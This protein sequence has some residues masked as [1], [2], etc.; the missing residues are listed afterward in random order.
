MNIERRK[1]WSVTYT[2]LLRDPKGML[3]YV[4]RFELLRAIWTRYLAPI[5]QFFLD[6]RTESKT[7]TV[8]NHH[9]NGNSEHV[10]LR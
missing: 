8:P 9:R 10:P 6:V 3:H 7:K 1:R 4:P 5:L 2:G